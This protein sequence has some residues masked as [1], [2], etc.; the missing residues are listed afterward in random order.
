MDGRIIS[1]VSKCN[2][3]GR[4]ETL[5]ED[6]VPPKIWNNNTEKKYSKAY[7]T[8]KPHPNAVNAFPY[9]GR[10]GITYKTICSD[11][12]NRILGEQDKSLKE[13][14]DGIRS[15][16]KNE[17]IRFVNIEISVN[18]VCRAI[19]GHLLSAKENYDDQTL[20]DRALRN[21]VLNNDILPP[22]EY[23]LFYYIYPFDTIVVARDMVVGNV[24]DSSNSYELPDGMISVLCSYPLAIILAPDTP[25]NENLRLPDLFSSCTESIDDRRTILI[26]K[27]KMYFHNTGKLRPCFWPLEID[28][29]QNAANIVLA[30]SAMTSMVFAVGSKQR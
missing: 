7:G 24:Y 27:N 20:I 17:R 21:Y 1:E 12:N 5:T 6:H 10:K 28:D 26:D 25:E 23:K 14:I 30:G 13:L 2:I 29:C 4:L 19:A 3:C 8:I 16:F 22:K 18:K 9:K 15:G 11:C